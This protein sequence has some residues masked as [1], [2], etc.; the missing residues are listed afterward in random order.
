MK[1]TINRTIQPKIKSVEQ[2]SLPKPI[3]SELDNGIKVYAFDAGTEEVIKI[4]FVVEAGSWYQDKKL[5]AFSTIKMLTEGTKN[6]TA[7][8]LAEIFDFYGAYVETESERDYTYITLY[9]LNKNVEKLLPVFAEIIKEP[10]FPKKELSVL[11]TN[12]KQDQ[13]VSMQKVS[14]VARIKFAEQLYGS[15]HPYGISPK[16]EDYRKITTDDLMQFYKKYYVPENIRIVISGKIQKNIIELLNTHFGKSKNTSGKKKITKLFPVEPAKEKKQIILQQNALQSG[17]RL[18]KILFSRN[19]PDFIGMNILSTILGGYF[20]SR[21]MT[22]IREDKGYTYGIGSA[23]IS[24]RHSGYIFIASDVSANCRE[25]AVDEI[26]KEIERLRKEPVPQ[27]E[28]ELVKN[29]MAGTFL[30]KIDGPFAIAERFISTLD[31][32]L[33]FNEYFTNYINT[34]KSITSEEIIKLASRHLQNNSFF[35]TICGK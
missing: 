11:L 28:L 23:I 35:E 8:E 6:H 9:T 15:S 18:G 12:T 3:I 21:L 20:G 29:Y 10:V 4:E 1:T 2:V 7:A 17:L 30:R 22:N 33:D 24:M 25:K 14:Y 5:Q 16:P 13:M 32:G 19:H 31:Y 34:I 27:K 26:Y